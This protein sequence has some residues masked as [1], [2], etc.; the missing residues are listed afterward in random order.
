MQ[1][2]KKI[3][4]KIS[5][6][7]PF[8]VINTI[9]LLLIAVVCVYPFLYIF[10]LSISDGKYLVTNQVKVFPMGVNFETFK[11]IFT[12]KNL[13]IGR[14]MFNSAIYTIA[15]TATSIFITFSTAYVL[16]RKRF[17]G[18]FLIMSLFAFTWVFE[19]GIIPNY[20]ILNSLG[21][22]DNPLVM[23]IPNAIN[24]QFLILTKVF[25]EGLPD[26]LEEAARI[27]GANDW[28][29]MIKIFVPLSKTII[30][31]IGLFYAV[32]IWNQY[33]VPQ[34][35]LKS[36]QYQTIQQILKQLVI[37]SGSANTS[38]S[39]FVKNGISLNP[40]NLRAAAIF[41]AMVPIVCVYPFVQKYF[42]KGILVGSVKG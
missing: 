36:A 40:Q 30:A 41:V 31:T 13:N 5:K 10:F 14:G 37:S 8:D 35:Y 7:K 20:I 29:T 19:A 39:T 23:I 26:E 15:G 32:F 9:I 4:N 16:T 6:V 34:I 17:K 21:F 33:L 27:D 25:L 1:K 22:V 38:F 3:K 42:K 28:I 24:T 18:R 12:N 11:Y 2:D